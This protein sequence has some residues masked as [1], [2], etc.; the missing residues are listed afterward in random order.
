[1]V[2][3]SMSVV[4]G[5]R[6][7]MADRRVSVA[8]VRLRSSLVELVDGYDYRRMGRGEEASNTR[9]SSLYRGV[10]A[11]GILS[12]ASGPAAYNGSDLSSGLE[13]GAEC[14]LSVRLL[15]L[16]GR[17][18]LFLAGW[19]QG[20]VSGRVN[21]SLRPSSQRTNAGRRLRPASLHLLS[22]ICDGRP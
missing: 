7:L 21:P 22:C 18:V 11:L 4:E 10:R 19:L 9:A 15:R 20:T 12:L 16:Q 5:R 2:G 6:S 1:M 14:E 13:R 8:K 3:W 17:A